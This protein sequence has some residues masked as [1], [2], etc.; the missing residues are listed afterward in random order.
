ML[1]DIISPMAYRLFP[2]YSVDQPVGPGKPNRHDDVRLIQAM[3]LT[4]FR[5]DTA[6]WVS[7][8]PADKRIL[9]TNAMFNDTLA[10]WILTFQTYYGTGTYK[11]ILFADGVVDPLPPDIRDAK[12]RFKH[13]HYST[14]WWMCN[15]LWK[16]SQKDYMRLGDHRIPWNPEPHWASS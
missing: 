11:G 12:A 7:A 16:H 9:T 14:L 8:L 4:L 13:G 2:M 1:C 6:D 5:F 15:R 3:L 10:Q